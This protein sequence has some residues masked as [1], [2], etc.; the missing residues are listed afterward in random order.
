MRKK[1][2]NCGDKP[3]EFSVFARKTVVVLLCLF[4]TLVILAGALIGAFFALRTAG[5]R[6]F[7]DRRQEQINAETQYSSD[8]NVY[9]KFSVSYEG[10]TYRYNQKLT[11]FIVMGIDGSKSTETEEQIEHIGVAGAGQA[12][13][14]M[15]LVLDEE[16]LAADIIAV[17]RNSMS[18]F[19]AYDSEGKSLGA[20][21]SQLA[22]S[23]AYGDGAHSSCKMTLNAVSDFMYGIPIHAYYSMKRQALRDVNDA[24]GGVTLTIPVDMTRVHKSFVE[25]AT[26]TLTGKLADKFIGARQGVGDGSNA[27]R[28]SR[29]QLYLKAFISSAI[30]AVKKDWSL[31]KKI[32]EKIA[33]NSCTDITLDEMVYLADLVTKLDFSFHTIPG[34]TD[35]DGRYA[36]FRPDPEEFYKLILDIFYVC[37]D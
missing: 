28:I 31:P 6:S 34:E 33:E 25:G 14:I 20:L 29:Q 18:Y 35:T 1:V 8:E 22:I 3:F 21:E 36:E 26:V 30:E 15:V 5:K 7:D 2:K 24:V 13:A 37:E 9:D 32:Y 23:Y 27:G 4:A 10:K 16:N 17:D 12:D 19:E 11:T